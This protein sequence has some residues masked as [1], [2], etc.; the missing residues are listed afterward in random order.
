[1]LDIKEWNQD[2]I[3]LIEGCLDR[4][5]YGLSKEYTYEKYRRSIAIE[6]L[7]LF[8]TQKFMDHIPNDF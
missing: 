4:F 5:Y 7:C 6:L 2:D 1:M 8:A 3:A